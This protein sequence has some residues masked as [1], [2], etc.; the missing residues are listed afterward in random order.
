VAHRLSTLTKFERIIVLERG[1]IVE[2]GSVAE[3]RGRGGVFERMW[4]AQVEGL[5]VGPSMEHAA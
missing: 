2:D 5:E 4:R 1:K 3:L